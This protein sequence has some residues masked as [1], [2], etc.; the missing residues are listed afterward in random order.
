[1]T[2][3]IADFI[4]KQHMYSPAMWVIFVL[5]LLRIVALIANFQ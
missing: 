4:V 2:P 3:E 1:M 5:F